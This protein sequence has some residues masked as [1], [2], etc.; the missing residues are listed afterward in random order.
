MEIT[1]DVRESGNPCE[2]HGGILGTHKIPTDHGLIAAEAAFLR[3]KRGQRIRVATSETNEH[4]GSGAKDGDLS[5]LTVRPLGVR[6]SLAVRFSDGSIVAGA[7]AQRVFTRNRGWLRLAE[8]TGEDIVERSHRIVFRGASVSRIPVRAHVVAEE[9]VSRRPLRL[10]RR[11]G[12]RLCHYLGWLVGDGCLTRH[13]AVTVYGSADD[14]R[15]VMPVHRELLNRIGM[16]PVKPVLQGNGTRQL[17][18]MRGAFVGFL[19]ELGFSRAR[20][21][22][23]V[24]PSAVCEAPS[25][26]V[27]A[28]LRGLFD[29]DGCVVNQ[30]TNQT[31]YVGL[32]SASPELL[33]DVQQ[34]LSSCFGITGRIYVSDSANR[35]FEYTRKR[36]GRAVT[37]RALG[38]AY[39][40]RITGN[41]IRKFCDAVGFMLPTKQERLDG[42]LSGGR[43][44][45]KDPAVRM[46]RSE[47]LGPQPVFALT[48]ESGE[49]CIVGGFII[50]GQ[51]ITRRSGG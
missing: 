15:F 13:G 46:V 12:A 31:R 50:P 44:Y 47:D 48:T 6:E 17:R 35:T 8:L 30:E 29:A 41:G 25:A 7:S 1:Q 3:L 27:G 16:G 36:D 24:V 34:L 9:C 51:G 5:R 37:Y 14:Q 4:G 18:L 22:L 39:D 2:V 21:A 32:G 43:F 19:G 33:L 20:A 11:W 42:V 10:P 40:L 49:D 38:P 23:K 28:F 26:A 45:R